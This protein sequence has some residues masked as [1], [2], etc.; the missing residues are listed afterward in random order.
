[1]R[2]AG[3][4]L[5]HPLRPRRRH[6]H[7]AW[8]W[9][10]GPDAAADAAARRQRASASVSQRLASAH[11]VGQADGRRRAARRS[12]RT[13]CSRCRGCGGSRPAARSSQMSARRRVEQVG[14]RVAS[15]MAAL[16]QDIG[17]ARGRAG[18]AAAASISARSAGRRPPQ[19]RA[20]LGQVGRD[21]VAPAAAGARAG[22]PP[23][24]RAAA[25]RRPWRPSPGRGRRSGGRHACETL[26][27]RRHD[28]GACRACR[29]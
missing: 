18:A 11:G 1:M 22:R 13:A 10:T 28:L 27:H 20:G 8:K 9:W 6:G 4:R 7:R 23:P 24:R 3:R 16:E 17:A 21:Q 15:Q 25:G 14:A 12:P 29:S 5:R 26:G 19:Q 2:Q